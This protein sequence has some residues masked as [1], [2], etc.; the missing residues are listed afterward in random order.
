[1]RHS[2]N[3]ISDQL[4]HLST[5]QVKYSNV[6][7][8][9]HKLPP[10]YMKA[11]LTLKYTLDQAAKS[12]ILLLKTGLVASPPLRSSFVREP[13]IPGTTGIRV[14]SKKGS[15]Q[16]M[17]LFSKLWDDQQLRLLGLPGLAD[18]IESLVE[19]DQK[20]KAKL[21]PWVAQVFSDI[22][23]IAHV[24]HELVSL[25]KLFSLSPGKILKFHELLTAKTF[26]PIF[27]T[28]LK[29]EEI[30]LM[31]YWQ[32]LYQPWAA[33]YDNAEVDHRDAIQKEFPR[34]FSKVADIVSHLGNVPFAKFGA[35]TEGRFYYPSDKRRTQ[36]NVESMREAE[37]HLDIFWEK[38]DEV[39]QKKNGKSLEQGVQYL[40]KDRRPLERTEIW[41]E[42]IKESKRLAMERNEQDLSQPLSALQ[43][44]SVDSSSRFVP[45]QEKVKPKT[46]GTTRDVPG[47]TTEPAVATRPEDT[48]PTFKLKNR[49]FKVFKSLFY[50][51]SQNDL[52]GEIL[53]A[54][55]LFAMVA[56]GFAPEKLY[57]SVWQF[58]PSHLDVERSIQFHE[59]HP[60]GKIPFRNARRIGRRL[61][62]AYGWHGG[63]FALE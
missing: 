51:P 19:R 18:E 1:M 63:M 49:S 38:V 34:R 24:Q 40:F 44:G 39:Y 23:L 41:V 11:L 26:L 13:H 9:Q 61:N 33:G 60:V 50:K 62:R 22:G 6:I 16:L 25:L 55:F 37:K 31:A 5:L 52:P 17:W 45:P 27:S 48:Q 20:E 43:L 47:T 53:W 58:T 42:P 56:T 29:D 36:Q 57:G 14:Q 32:E 30:L 8:P 4:N 21:S 59:P 28:R 2:R 54:D 35:P 7:D 10:E 46:R 3:I 15:D 12:P